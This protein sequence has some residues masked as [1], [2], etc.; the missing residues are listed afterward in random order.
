MT[1]ERL[2]FAA[3]SGPAWRA[4]FP[5]RQLVEIEDL[6]SCPRTVRD[7]ATDYLE[8]VARLGRVSE[9]V[10]PILARALA[11]TGTRQIV[12]L[13]SGGGGPWPSLLAPLRARL[14]DEVSV[15]L[16][17]L[18][19]NAGAKAR[20]R[21]AATP[22]VTAWPVPVDAR[23]VPPELSGLRTIFTAFHHFPPAEATAI[24]ADAVRQRQGIAIFELTARRARTLAAILLGPLLALALAPLVHPPRASRLALT[25]LLPVIPAVILWDGIVSCVRTYTVD[26]MRGLA[27]DAGGEGYAWEAGTIPLRRLPVPLTYLVGYPRPDREMP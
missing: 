25:F 11:A 23:R 26:E 7:G 21:R 8:L 3:P 5:R 2:P 6:P 19:P 18:Y 27:R 20:Q 12:D 15:C 10:A 1:T 16:T 22:E 14:G 4:R 24:L 13:C 9:A 17:D